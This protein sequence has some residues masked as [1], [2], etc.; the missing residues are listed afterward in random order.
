[1]K[2]VTR[3]AD[4]LLTRSTL[5]WTTLSMTSHKEGKGTV[6]FFFYLLFAEEEV[7]ERS[8]VGVS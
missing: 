6:Y 1:M 8:N 2:C 4:S 5:G 3:R 7:S